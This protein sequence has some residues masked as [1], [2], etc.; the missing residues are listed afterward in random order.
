MIFVFYDIDL[1]NFFE[2][3]HFFFSFDVNEKITFKTINEESTADI[4]RI[5][6]GET[7]S[8]EQI[9][10]AKNKIKKMANTF[11]FK[12]MH[13]MYKKNKLNEVPEETREK[14]VEKLIKCL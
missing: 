5:I 7:P 10:Y 11:D 13:P 14:V 9:I 1:R 8:N 3:N 6:Y 2:F 12:D 4:L